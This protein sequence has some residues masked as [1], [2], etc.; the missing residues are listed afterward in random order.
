L[1]AMLALLTTRIRS[2][3]W[4]LVVGFNLV[5]TIDILVDYYQG[6][7]LGL[8]AL[9]GELGGAYAVVIVYVPILMI[10][11][12]ISIYLLFRRQSEVTLAAVRN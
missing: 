1:L 10:S 11:H 4:P 9:A 2:L 6:G 8:P 12:F 5:G 7:K 3:F